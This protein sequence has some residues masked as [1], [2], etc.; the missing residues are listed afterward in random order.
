MIPA[1]DFLSG[2]T[3]FSRAT[4]LLFRH[5]R[6]LLLVLLPT[7]INGVL[8]SFFIYFAV[9]YFNV[10]L[11]DLMQGESWIGW[12]VVRH[13]WWVLY[14]LLLMVAC[15]FTFVPVGVLL[16]APFSDQLS[17]KV[18]NLLLAGHDKKRRRGYVE[19]L[20]VSCAHGLLRFVIMVVV[21]LALL[22]L[23][24]IPIVGWV[25]LTYVFIFFLGWEGFEYSLSRYGYGFREKL[26]F[27][28][29]HHAALIGLGVAGFLLLLVPLTALFVFP[30]L[31]ASG[32]VLYCEFES[33][34]VE[35]R[36]Q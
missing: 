11:T 12:P 2:F 36:Q 30:M 22:P 24:L 3:S 35:G 17:G 9:T 15:Y 32:A 34:R 27:F 31:A 10:W 13:F 26:R 14:A 33:D 8:Y 6:Y 23:Q 4:R 20:V 25:P 29:R 19:V 1:G 28:G 16:S 18:E 7:A 5:P 21:V